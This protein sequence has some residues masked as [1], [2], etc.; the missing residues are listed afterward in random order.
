MRQPNEVYLPKARKSDLVTRQIPGE[1]LIYDLKRH[2]AFCLNGT[3]AKIWKSCDGKRTVADLVAILDDRRTALDERIVWLALDQLERSRLL[4]SGGRGRKELPLISRRLLIR[5]GIAAG[6]ALPIVTM[7]AAP[8]AL[9]QASTI[10][11]SDCAKI[12]TPNCPGSL[13]TD[14]P[15]KTCLNLGMANCGCG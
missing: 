14:K 9:A 12:P 7:I 15:G 4:Q 13:C 10:H 11:S 8:T 6:I 2:K 5:S 1:L 3:A